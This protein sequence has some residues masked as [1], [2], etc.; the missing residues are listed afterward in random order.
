MF[1]RST[2]Q[3]KDDPDREEREKEKAAKKKEEL[4]EQDDEEVL[5]KA[6]QWDEWKDGKA[7]GY[8]SSYKFFLQFSFH[9]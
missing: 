1:D 2:P 3:T 7:V 6:R 4:E 5:R 9:A 8:L